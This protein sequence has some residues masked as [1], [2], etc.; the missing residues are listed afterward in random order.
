MSAPSRDTLLNPITAAN[1][2]SDAS[3]SRRGSTNIRVTEP[4]QQFKYSQG[5]SFSFWKIV[6]VIVLFLLALVS[7]VV[8]TELTSVLFSSFDFDEPV[9]L[10]FINHGSWWL[11]WPIQF[12]SIAF[13]NASTKYI[14]HLS[15]QAYNSINP[16]PY[17]GFR[18]A[19]ASSVKA[20]HQNIFHTAELTTHANISNYE[21]IYKDSQKSFKK[22]T[23]FFQSQ[24][25]WYMFK[26]AACLSIILNIAGFTWFIA[27][28][29]STGSDVTAIYN[30]SAFTAYIF[31]IPILKEKFSWLKAN[32][33]STAIAGVFIVAY[34]GDTSSNTSGQ[35]PYRVWGNMI[36]LIGA[37]LYGLYEVFYKKWC[38]PPSELVSARRQATFS[39]FV[40]CLMGINSLIS[41]G[42]LIISAHVTGLH[43]FHIPTDLT[44]WLY[45]I[46]SVVANHLFSVSFLGLMSLT[47]PVLSSVASLLT[48]LVVG[49]FEWIWRGIIITFAQIIGYFFIIV[50]FALLS[51]ASWNEI[52]NEDVDDDDYITDAESTYSTSS[53]QAFA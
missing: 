40:M 24:A 29:L 38:C 46:G 39:N 21:I 26:M 25:I 9:L 32:S 13:F 6:F 36:I 8:Q 12:L 5:Y 47:S 41:V 3:S 14:R 35:Y 31:A 7:F 19:F 50:G 51:Y 44:I 10:L 20:Q 43:K 28:K 42:I 1:Y 45:I 4:P 16:K 49:V 2:T 52:S 22:Y 48:I 27:M 17:K 23:Q 18:R 53:S 30:C 34:M 15:G 11:L 33:V 37:I